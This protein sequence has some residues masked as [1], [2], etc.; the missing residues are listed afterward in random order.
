MYI[1]VKRLLL[2]DD[3]F[4]DLIDSNQV[5]EKIGDMNE[6]LEFSGEAQL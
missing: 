6:R 3:F 4:N 1:L 2:S 5:M